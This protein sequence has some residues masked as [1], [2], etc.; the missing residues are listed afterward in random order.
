[1]RVRAFVARVILSLVRK[2]SEVVLLVLLPLVDHV[3]YARTAGLGGAGLAMLPHAR[4]GRA[5]TPDPGAGL[6]HTTD[7][8]VP[9][10]RT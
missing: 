3:H 4:V 6:V 8:W 1:V 9:A 10:Q 2:V 7:G 5:L